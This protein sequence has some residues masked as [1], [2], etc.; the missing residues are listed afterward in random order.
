M[1]SGSCFSNINRNGGK[2]AANGSTE[3]LPCANGFPATVPA[4]YMAD[5][6]C[7]QKSRF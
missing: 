2:N 6:D 7:S 1:P 4:I 3:N 5:L